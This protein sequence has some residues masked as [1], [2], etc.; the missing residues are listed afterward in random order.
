MNDALWTRHLTPRRT[1]AL[2]AAWL[3][4]QGVLGWMGGELQK[5]GAQGPPDL[6]FF[7]T[8][9]ALIERIEL[10]GE[11]GRAFYLR[12]FYVDWVYPVTYSLLFAS[13]VVLIGRRL[14]AER[15]AALIA[16]LFFV[17]ALADWS[18]N[19]CFI[20]LMRGWPET[21]DALVQAGCWFNQIKWGSLV[22][23]LLAGLGGL[24]VLGL[25]R[26]RVQ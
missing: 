6:L 26:A 2:L 11:A 9:N 22:L 25:R 1:F 17:G 10:M 7:A 20:A 5:D 4:F 18:E 19:L 24:L 3:G 13:I 23:A 14:G 21:P 8:P 15:G 16:P 12:T